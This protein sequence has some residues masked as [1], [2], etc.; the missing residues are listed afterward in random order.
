MP[1]LTTVDIM[2]DTDTVDTADMVMVDTMDK[3]HLSSQIQ[4]DQVT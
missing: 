4:K 2:V 3:C 1:K